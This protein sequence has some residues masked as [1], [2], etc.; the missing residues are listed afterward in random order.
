MKIAILAWGSILWEP[1]NIKINKWK[2]T[3]FRLP[4]NFARI[5]DAGK[6][7]I[8]L[9]IDQK[10]GYETPVQYGIMKE[11]NLN[12]A[13]N[14]LKKRERTIYKNVGFINL[15]N[16]TFRTQT[17]SINPYI[18]LITSWA[19]KNQISGVIWTDLPSNWKDIRGTNFNIRD[20]LNYLNNLREHDIIVY[21]KCVEYIANAL[22]FGGICLPLTKSILGQC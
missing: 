17:L 2:M 8:T 18:N 3:D 11:Q 1:K 13:I 6:G 7:R 12:D 19:Q 20:A 22:R 15:K 4:I 14:A 10:Y 9:V 5:S 16:N 21:N